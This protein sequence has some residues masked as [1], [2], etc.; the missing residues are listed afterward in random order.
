[1]GRVVRAHRYALA[2][3]LVGRELPGWEMALHECDPLCVR[4]VDPA[5]A[6]PGTASHVVTGSQRQ[7][8]ARMAGVAAAGDGRRFRCTGAG[9]AMAAALLDAEDRLTLW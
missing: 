9:L 2:V 4:V 8:M 3:V 1:L 5:T 6:A 7:N